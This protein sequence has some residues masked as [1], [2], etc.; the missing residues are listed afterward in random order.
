M[1]RKFYGQGMGRTALGKKSSISC[2]RPVNAN[3]PK[4]KPNKTKQTVHDGCGDFSIQSFYV[5]KKLFLIKDLTNFSTS[6]L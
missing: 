6:C 2:L 5:F 1:V 4:K 3:Q